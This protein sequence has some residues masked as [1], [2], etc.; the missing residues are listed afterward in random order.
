MR[1]I[2]GKFKGIQLNTF[3]YGNIRPTIDRVRENVF[4]KIQ[5]RIDKSVVLD[6][7]AGTGAISL[8]FISRGASKVFVCDNNKDS[9]NLIKKNFQKCRIAPLI[10]E[11]DYLEILNKL[12][13][14]KFDI[15]FLDP[16]FECDFGEKTLEFIAKNKMLLQNGIIIYEHVVGKKFY[17]PQEL[18]VV[19]ERKYGT[20]EVTYLEFEND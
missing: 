5:F 19:D 6:L 7:F 2:A 3:E 4:N 9:I 15:I 16:P 18:K 1:I 11:G 12:K 8:E 13:D 17:I 20:I 10:L 14:T